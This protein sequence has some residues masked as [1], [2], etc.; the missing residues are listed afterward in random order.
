MKDTTVNVSLSSVK[1]SL[2]CS[3][4]RGSMYKENK[5]GPRIG[6]RHTPDLIVAK[7]EERLTIF[8]KKILLVR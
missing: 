8:L 5:T 7:E 3:I 4:L 6:P 2:L 1:S